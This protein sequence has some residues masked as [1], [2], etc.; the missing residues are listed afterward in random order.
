MKK[1]IC[2]K[3]ISKCD[4]FFYMQFLRTFKKQSFQICSFSHKKVMGYLKFFFTDWT[5]F[6]PCNLPYKLKKKFLCFK[7]LSIKS[8][9]QILPNC[10]I[11]QTAISQIC[12]SRSTRT[13]SPS[14]PQYSFPNASCGTSEGLTN[15]LWKIAQLGNCHPLKYVNNIVT[16]YSQPKDINQSQE[17][18]TEYCNE[19][20][21]KNP[22][23]RNGVRQFCRNQL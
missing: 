10:A 1:K 13:P 11:S 16:P 3:Q 4:A 23:F 12:P 18:K 14:Q 15:N 8:P 6:L 9:M 22:V 7:L 19:T 21:Y 5:F 17:L 2:F 20:Q